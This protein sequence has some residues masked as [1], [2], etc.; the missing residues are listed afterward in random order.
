[1][2]T[3]NMC[4]RMNEDEKM[5]SIKN[6]TYFCVKSPTVF[7]ENRIWDTDLFFKNHRKENDVRSTIAV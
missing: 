2:E 5:M 6:K 4:I 3:L 7:T 1:M